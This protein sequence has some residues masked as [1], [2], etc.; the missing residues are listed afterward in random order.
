[1][2]TTIYTRQDIINHLSS[3]NCPLAESQIER[4][5]PEKSAI[6]I[7]NMRRR[8]EDRYNAMTDEEFIRKVRGCEF[9]VKIFAPGLFFIAND[10]QLFMCQNL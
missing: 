5:G 2:S 7:N 8:S 6:M 3:A 9:D 10:I 1:M 4:H